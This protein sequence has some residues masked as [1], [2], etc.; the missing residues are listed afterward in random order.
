M[1]SRNAMEGDVV[2][3][4]GEVGNQAVAPLRNVA[5]AHLAQGQ[6]GGSFEGAHF[7][8]CARSASAVQLFG[9]VAVLETHTL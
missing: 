2:P 4:H 6:M 8:Q 9:Y 5:T 3:A 7:M 1:A